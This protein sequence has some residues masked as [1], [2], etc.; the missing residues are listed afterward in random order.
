[1]SDTPPP[2]HA[3]DASVTQGDASSGEGGE[4][5]LESL[6]RDIP[7]R[8]GAELG[9]ATLPLGQAVELV[10]GV[11]IELDRAAED[12]VDLCINGRRFATGHLMVIDDTEWAI[13]I[14]RLLDVDIA[15]WVAGEPPAPP[16]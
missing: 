9:R 3:T 13:R 4:L 11:V 8:V 10:P 16:Q 14:D 7:V 1:V 2:A 6:L 5:T 12:P 15:D